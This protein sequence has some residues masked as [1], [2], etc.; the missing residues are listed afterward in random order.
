MNDLQKE[1]A[2][3]L[4]TWIE[5][6]TQGL[7][8]HK[9]LGLFEQTITALWTTSR[10]I[11]SSVLLLAVSERVLFHGSTHHPILKLVE[12]N[13]SGFNFDELR[14]TAKKISHDQIVAALRQVLTDFI[15]ILGDIT[16]EVL[17]P[18]L[19]QVLAKINLQNEHTKK[20]PS[21]NGEV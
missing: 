17:S 8:S 18:I 10:S 2:A 20:S 7:S 6:T 21:E 4:A 5:A 16:N 15:S 9:T 3:Q 13:V 1:H 14:K 12:V 19:F 11:L